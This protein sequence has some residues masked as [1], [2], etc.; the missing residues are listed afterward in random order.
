MI[1]KYT[2]GVLLLHHRTLLMYYYAVY[3]INERK[4]VRF[5]PPNTGVKHSFSREI[6]EEIYFFPEVASM[7][8]NISHL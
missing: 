4:T 5:F 3:S 1:S 6:Q 8:R 2:N 7:S